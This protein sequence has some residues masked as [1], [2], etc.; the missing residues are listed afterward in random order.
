M[1]NRFSM[2]IANVLLCL[3]SQSPR[4]PNVAFAVSEQVPV[5][6]IILC[7][8][9]QRPASPGVVRARGHGCAETT[10]GLDRGLLETGDPCRRTLGTQRLDLPGRRQHCRWLIWLPT[11]IPAGK[12]LLKEAC[13][14]ARM[15]RSN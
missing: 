9:V 4:S 10:S 11:N 1:K 3:S 13:L 8:A 6:H 15:R 7:P 12:T 5:H 14:L 2:M